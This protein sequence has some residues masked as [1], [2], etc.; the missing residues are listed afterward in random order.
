MVHLKMCSNFNYVTRSIL[1]SLLNLK[2]SIKIET[3]SKE[4]KATNKQRHGNK[5]ENRKLIHEKHYLRVGFIESW[6]SG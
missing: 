4:Q 6:R 3:Q 2:F 1:S 5:Q